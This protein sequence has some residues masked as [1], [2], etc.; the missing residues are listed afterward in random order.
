MSRKRLRLE[1]LLAPILLSIRIRKGMVFRIGVAVHS[2]K[3]FQ[4]GALWRLLL[5]S[6]SLLYWRSEASARIFGRGS[7]IPDLAFAEL[8]PELHNQ[9][10]RDILAVTMRFDRPYPSK[11][12]IKAVRLF[13]DRHALRIV[14]VSQVRRDSDRAIQLAKDLCAVEA[15]TWPNERSIQE[16]E[17]QL[18][19]IYTKAAIIVSDRLHALIAAMN[20]GATPACMLTASSNKVADHFSVL[21]IDASLITAESMKTQNYVAFMESCLQNRQ[22]LHRA[23]ERAFHPFNCSLP[24]CD[25][26]KTI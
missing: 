18:F 4:I 1:L 6:T 5:R 14:T 19:P 13:A 7:L 25:G 3:H 21:G 16:Q 8:R 11:N 9:T 17:Q 10:G 23:I 12:L 22:E 24:I 20:M 15:I 26:A 2:S